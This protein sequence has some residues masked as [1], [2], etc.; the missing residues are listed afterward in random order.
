MGG[1]ELGA[2]ALKF[3]ASGGGAVSSGLKVS[4]LGFRFRV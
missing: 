3:K 2:F 4:D 1:G